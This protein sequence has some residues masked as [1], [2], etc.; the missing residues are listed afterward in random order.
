MRNVVSKEKLFPTALFVG[1][2]ALSGCT[3]SD[4]DLSKVDMTM[5]F[6]GD[7]I[8]LPTSSTGVIQLS[9]VLDLEADGSVSLDADSN[10]VFRLAE[11]SA[12]PARPH[13]DALS[14]SPSSHDID[15]SFNAA[16]TAKPHGATRAA[17]SYA[18]S[19][20]DQKFP[21]YEYSGHSSVVREL[22]SAVIDD[23]RMTLTFNFIGSLSASIP[24]IAKMHFTLPSY[25]DIK[26]VS[27]TEGHGTVHFT[28]GTS[29]LDLLNVQTTQPL[30]LQI[31]V[32][33]L[34]FESYDPAYG[35]LSIDSSTGDIVLDG[36]LGMGLEANVVGVP[37]T[38]SFS[39]HAA[40]DLDPINVASASGVFDPTINL[41]KLGETNVTGVPDF[42]SDGNVCVDLYNPQIMLKVA[43]DMDVAAKVGGTVIAYK[44][45]RETA[46]VVLDEM[47]IHRSSDTADDTT[48][49]CVCRH[50]PAVGSTGVDYY[51]SPTLSSLI[52]TIPDRIE[53][54]DPQAHANLSLQAH[55]EFGRTYSV[56]PKYGV[57][58]PLAF[59]ENAVIVYKDSTDGWHDDLKDLELTDGSYV[60][61]T[62]DVES[63]VPV[64]LD[65]KADPVDVSGNVISAAKLNVEIP[66][67]INASADGKQPTATSVSVKISQLE[68]DALKLLDGLRFTVTG[69][70]TK[71]QQSVTGINLNA[72]DHTLRLS[73]IKVKVKGKVIGDFN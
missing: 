46:R 7:E 34:N 47:D 25:L 70:A 10:Y 2:L 26:S 36:Q 40:L 21:I 14:L 53:I 61:L 11:T 72:R 56:G 22:S 23:A 64:Y 60:E 42:L 32:G 55:V 62:A 29:S 45:G 41:G 57:V 69:T 59:A 73:N 50:L 19:I 65:I 18:I 58:A 24:E 67:G 15:F 20:A 54:V 3:N 39:I 17:S 66:N 28:P 49:I 63:R 71:G 38:T 48:R 16:S 44:N 43:N 13:I 6:G 12:D 51:E 68:D 30:K 35:Q 37:S 27:V 52:N 31:V 8:V 4:F 9:D 1:A 33:G 5:G